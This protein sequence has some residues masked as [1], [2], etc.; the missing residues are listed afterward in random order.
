MDRRGRALSG[1]VIAVAD[2]LAAAAGL[3]MIKS[4]GV[5]V[6]LIRGFEWQEADGSVRGLLRSADHDLFR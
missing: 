2:Q 6:V 5:P 4:E 3:L 1:T